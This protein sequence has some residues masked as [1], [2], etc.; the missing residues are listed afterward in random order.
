MAAICDLKI[1][2]SDDT[3]LIWV[4][5][6]KDM[7]VLDLTGALIVLKIVTP[8]ATITK[9]TGVDSDFVIAPDNLS[10]IWNITLADAKKI[11]NGAQSNYQMAVTRTAIRRTVLMG[12]VIGDGGLI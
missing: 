11:P 8:K 2:R 4:F 7:T 3:P 1:E 5:R 6:K 12:A 9:T 10:L